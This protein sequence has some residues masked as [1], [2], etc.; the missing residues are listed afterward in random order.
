MWGAP[1]VLLVTLLAPHSLWADGGL[2]RL[3]AETGEFRLIVFTSPTPLRAGPVDLSVMVQDRETREPVLDASVAVRLS[4][5][6]GGRTLDVAAT[7]DQATNRL[8]YTALFE[9]PESGRWRV[10][11][12]VRRGGVRAGVSLDLVAASSAPA[13]LVLWPYWILPL[14]VIVLFGLHQW[15]S[16]QLG[17]LNSRSVG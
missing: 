4:S 16:Q 3:A 17:R 6:P 2:L 10:E 12:D 8:L 13:L 1:L 5:G 9:L 11:L 15:R 14:L 7:R